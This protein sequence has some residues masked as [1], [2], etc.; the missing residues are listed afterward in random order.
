VYDW[1]SVAVDLEPILVGEAAR[2]FTATWYLDVPIMPSPEEAA[3]FVREYEQARGR[4]FAPAA[5]ET[6]R[7]AALYATAYT[8]RCEHA[9]DPRA[10]DF[11]PGSA[12]EAL[13]VYGDRFLAPR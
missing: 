9:R 10:G 2:S 13:A 4:A 1:D 3:A 5:R 6:L 8:A 7:A 12:R 11:P